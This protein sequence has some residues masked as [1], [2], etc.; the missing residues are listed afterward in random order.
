[1]TT[2]IDPTVTHVGWLR[3]RNPDERLGRWQPVANGTTQSEAWRA[4]YAYQERE[5][6]HRDL[7]VLPIGQKP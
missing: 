3:L 5:H 4:L 1:M 6:M 2:P 7:C